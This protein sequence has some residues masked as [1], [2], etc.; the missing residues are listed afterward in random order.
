MKSHRDVPDQPCYS[1]DDRRGLRGSANWKTRTRFFV[2]ETGRA[3]P[4]LPTRPRPYR[5]PG[6]AEPRWERPDWTWVGWSWG[7]RLRDWLCIGDGGGTSRV[8]SRYQTECASCGQGQSMLVGFVGDVHGPAYHVVALISTWQRVTQNNL[9]I[10]VQVGDMGAYPILDRMDESDRR[11]LELDPAQADFSRLLQADGLRG[12]RLRAIREEFAS[13]I[14]FLRGNHEDF[15]YLSELPREPGGTAKVDD[16][17][18]FRY[19]PDGTVL[20]VGNLR[21]AFLGGI[22]TEE[23]DQPSIDPT[24]RSRRRVSGSGC[25]FQAR[26]GPDRAYSTCAAHFGPRTPPEWAA[27]L[28]ALL[29][30][31]SRWSDLLRSVAPGR[32]RVPDGVPGGAGYRDVVLTADHRPMAA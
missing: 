28:R 17:H 6:L 3:P 7:L 4:L 15:R 9:D 19:V 5:L 21:I 23:P 14:H 11:H 22:E 29:V 18:L 30:V 16:F 20:Q 25:R 32:E 10:I 27:E 12:E 26:H 24:V 13:P 31:E 1:H 8:G 2:R